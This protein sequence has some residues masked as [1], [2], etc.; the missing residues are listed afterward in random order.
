MKK[1]LA[2][3]LAAM[4]ALSVAGC[5]SPYPQ[6]RAA[7]GAVLGGA[8]GALIGGA[9]TGRSSGA[10]V[11]GLVGAATGAAV[12]ASDPPPGPPRCARFGYDYNGNP[13]CLQYF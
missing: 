4:S 13:I 11:G 8:T 1:V 5:N 12:A 9:A 10:V 2:I 3:S 7:A 6:D